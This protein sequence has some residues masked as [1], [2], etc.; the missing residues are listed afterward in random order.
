MNKRNSQVYIERLSSY[1]GHHNCVGV[2]LSGGL[3]SSVLCALLSH[4]IGS[5]RIRAFHVVTELAEGWEEESARRVSKQIG[6]HLIVIKR[7]VLQDQ[8]ITCNSVGRCYFCKG[9]IAKEV[10]DI[11]VSQGIDLLCDGST[12]SDAQG[13]RPG[14][15]ALLELGV[16]SPLLVLEVK[17]AEVRKVAAELLPSFDF[18]SGSCMATRIK[19]GIALEPSLIRRLRLFEDEI[20][21]LGF[22][23]VRARY[24]G[25]CI[26]LEVQ[27][28]LIDLAIS[29][30]SYISEAAVNFG[31]NLVNISRAGYPGDI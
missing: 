30:E 20:R 14:A 11:A 23:L 3:D 18:V 2:M 28:D 26:N 8:R 16:K 15:K 6:I 5:E 21:A 9:Q 31:F 12:A 4:A 29:Y 10:S 22:K 17:R 27:P 1:I 24:D 13:E 7:S 25:A 19:K